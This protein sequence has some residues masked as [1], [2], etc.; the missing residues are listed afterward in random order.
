MLYILF[1]NLFFFLYNQFI[2]PPSLT[3]GI[4]QYEPFLLE[5]RMILE[6]AWY[7]FEESRVPSLPDCK[8]MSIEDFSLQIKEI[9]KNH[10]AYSHEVFS[11]LSNDASR[12]AIVFYIQS[13]YALNVRFYDLISLSLVA[14]PENTRIE[15][16]HNYWDEMGKGNPDETHIQLYRNVLNSVSSLSKNDYID[17]LGTNGLSGYNLLLKQV[18]AR[19]DYFRSIGALA[20]T[21]LADPQQYIKFIDGCKRVGIYS[22]KFK[23]YSEHIDIDALHGESWIDHVIIPVAN[24]HPE[25]RNQILEGCYMRLNTSAD[26]WDEIQE[27]MK[28]L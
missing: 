13:D 15:V 8:N 19:K 17:L 25:C 2:E 3:S 26:Y 1:K 22:D 12:E 7:Q 6:N 21:E 4:N 20:V 27:K 18:L 24:S 16:A 5:I 10:H 14:I 23:Y 9:W 11:Y 28:S